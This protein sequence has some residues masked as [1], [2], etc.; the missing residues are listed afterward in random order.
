[1][2]PTASIFNIFCRKF[3]DISIFCTAFSRFIVGFARPICLIS[4]ANIHLNCFERR[5]AAILSQHPLNLIATSWATL[6]LPPVE[7]W[8]QHALISLPISNL[9][10]GT[11]S[12]SGLMEESWWLGKQDAGS[13]SIGA[14]WQAALGS[15]RLIQVVVTMDKPSLPLVG[16]K[17]PSDQGGDRI[18]VWPLVESVVSFL[19]YNC[20]LS[21]HL[22]PL[23][24]SFINDLYF[25]LSSELLPRHPA[26]LNSLA[27]LQLHS[28]IVLFLDPRLAPQLPLLSQWR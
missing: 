14:S 16:A 4:F 18:N 19:L 20:A 15:L 8:H 11:H 25:F 3:E 5:S 1:M 10:L 23:Y 13:M 24:T 7:V 2:K 12:N 22:F 17:R 9:H 21:G 26:F 28:K 6:W 27:I